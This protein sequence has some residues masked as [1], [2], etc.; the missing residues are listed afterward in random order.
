MAIT[1]AM[2]RSESG[3]MFPREKMGGGKGGEL[4]EVK[5]ETDAVNKEVVVQ[6]EKRFLAR[7]ILVI[8]MVRFESSP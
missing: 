4:D 5:E 2:R 7:T 8:L 3:R 1:Q 6:D